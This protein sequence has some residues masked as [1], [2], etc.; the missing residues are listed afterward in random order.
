MDDPYNPDLVGGSL[1]DAASDER[2]QRPGDL[3]GRE[4]ASSTAVAALLG[5]GG[6]ALDGVTAVVTSR[7]L[8]P[9]GRGLY[10]VTL[11]VAAVVAVTACLG[12]TTAARVAIACSPPRVTMGQYLSIAPVHA[13]AGAIAGALATAG[14]V[15]GVLG[16]GSLGLVAASGALVVGMI[17]SSFVFDGLHALGHHRWATGTNAAGSLAALASSLAM[18]A[19]D[20]ATP[21]GFLLALTVAL[22][23]Q[24]AVG[25]VFLRRFAILTA[26]YDRAAHRALLH[27][28]L[29]GLPYL[30][31]TLIT[32]RLD[33][34]LVA[35]L[36]GLSAAGVYSVAATFAE[37]LRQV[38]NALGQIL[39]F[40]RTSGRIPRQ[41]ERRARALVVVATAAG[42]LVLGAAAD[43]LLKRLVGVE[44]AA[45]VV[46]LRILL[47]GEVFIAIWLLDSR[48]LLGSGRLGAAS[49]TTMISMVV[50]VVGDLLLV[51][52]FGIG[53]AAAAS[54]IAYAAAMVA[55]LVLLRSTQDTTA[56]AL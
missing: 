8:G 37:A 44:F 56:P 20:V 18:V 34:Y 2:P 4:V 25:L 3:G 40:G 54:V 10:A 45:A 32:F 7:M 50:L 16:T 6:A 24:V 27:S 55:A 21:T 17:L 23:I 41:L 46:P 47:V 22:A 38:P 5:F 35:S 53:G 12:V 43:P 31:S 9:A 15:V 11:T 51:P 36:A 52:L 1:P 48:L 33:R 49:A 39:A 14:L 42:L 13:A 26:G 29:P 30:S 28:G 19:A